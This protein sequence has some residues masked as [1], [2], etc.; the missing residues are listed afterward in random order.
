M[1]TLI[2]PTAD[3]CKA[4]QTDCITRGKTIADDCFDS[5]MADVMGEVFGDI[6]TRGVLCNIGGSLFNSK[7]P[8]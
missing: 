7:I 5:D 6:L 4:I 1:K 2:D 8:K 3:F